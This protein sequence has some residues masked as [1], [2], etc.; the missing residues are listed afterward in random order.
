ME[1]FFWVILCIS[2]G[3]TWAC[4]IVIPLPGERSGMGRMS[5]N[6]ING[7]GTLRLVFC[8]FF[9]LSRFLNTAPP[10]NAVFWWTGVTVAAIACRRI[11]ADRRLGVR[12]IIS[13]PLF[14]VAPHRAS[15]SVSASRRCLLSRCLPWRTT[16]GCLRGCAPPHHRYRI[17][18]TST[19]HG[20]GAWV[21]HQA[22]RFALKNAA[23]PASR[24]T[25]QPAHLLAYQRFNLAPKRYQKVMTGRLVLRFC[26]VL[27]MPSP[28]SLPAWLRHSG[29]KAVFSVAS[30]WATGAS[31]G[32]GLPRLL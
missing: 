24:Q 19:Y 4:I 26:A 1:V 23:S 2:Y 14:A 8:F 5:M 3:R 32:S 7:G 12:R 28:V 13:A 20:R 15:R 10:R 30:G 6:N 21:G 27:A 18:T 11:N 16:C 25:P 9:A 29:V 31:F 17:S 22:T